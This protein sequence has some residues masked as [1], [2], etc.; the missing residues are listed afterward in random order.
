MYCSH[1]SDDLDA[2]CDDRFAVRLCKKLSK[3]NINVT[4][5]SND[6]YAN[7]HNHMN[8][9]SIATKYFWENN[10]PT[11]Q[12]VHLQNNLDNI[13]DTHRLFYFKIVA[14]QQ[15]NCTIVENHEI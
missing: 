1:P 3:Y 7:I 12:V 9:P 2:E 15:N 11:Y 8:L 5:L 13:C 14:T 6:R 10:N 4:L